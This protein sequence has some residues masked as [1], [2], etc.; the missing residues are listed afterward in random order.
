LL[1]TQ[2]HYTTPQTIFADHNIIYYMGEAVVFLLVKENRVLLEFRQIDGEEVMHIPGGG[3]ESFDKT[4]DVHYSINAMHREMREEFD[5]KVEI[6]TYQ[7]LGRIIKEE[8]DLLFHVYVVTHWEGEIPSHTLEEGIPDGRLEWH[9][10]DEAIKIAPG[11]TVREYTLKKVKE[12]F[13][14]A[15]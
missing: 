3:I 5:G 13:E 15:K 10:L 4:G 9:E 2:Q 1:F 14:Q 12:F 11:N 6:K 8:A 7:K